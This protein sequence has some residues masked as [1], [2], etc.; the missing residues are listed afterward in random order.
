MCPVRTVTYVS[1][2]SLLGR[3]ASLG[4]VLFAARRQFQDFGN[5]SVK[6]D[7]QRA[8]NRRKHVPVDQ[9]A[10]GFVDLGLLVAAMFL[11]VYPRPYPRVSVNTVLWSALRSDG[12]VAHVRERREQ[13]LV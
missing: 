1:G 13:R 8:F 11:V 2:R 6:V 12:T 10:Q 5:L 9:A 3:L 4:S 7:R